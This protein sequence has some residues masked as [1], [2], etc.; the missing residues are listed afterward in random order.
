MQQIIKAGPHRNTL[1][2]IGIPLAVGVVA[3]FIP[4]VRNLHFESAMIASIAGCFIAAFVSARLPGKV[5]E[6]NHL[7]KIGGWIYLTA[8]V[9]LISALIRGCFSMDGLLFWIFNPSLS[10]LF[11]Y[12]VGRYFRIN[13]FRRSALWANLI[14]IFVAIG[15]LLFELYSLPQLYFFNHVWGYWPGPIYDEEVTFTTSVILFRFITLC[16]VGLFWLI[17]HFW[18]HRQ[19]QYLTLIIL[20]GLT[21]SY[22]RLSESGIVSPNEYI[23]QQLGSAEHTES[24]ELFF[25]EDHTPEP[26]LNRLR[27]LHEF[28]IGELADTLNVDSDAI[29]SYIYPHAWKKKK[30]TGAKFTSYV[31]VWHSRD[32]LHINRQ[33]VD[34]SLRH[35]LTHVI[36]KEFGNRLLN[37]SWSIGLLEGV[38]V[39]LAPAEQRRATADQMVVANEAWLEPEELNRLFSITG[40]Y[41]QAGPMSY[42]IAGSFVGYLLKNYPVEKFKTA[43]RRSSLDAGYETPLDSLQAGW[44]RHL[45]TVEVDEKAEMAGLQAFAIPSIFDQECPRLV[46]TFQDAIDRYRHHL[47]E[48]DTS[49]AL[50][51]LDDAI[52]AEPDNPDAVYQ[53]VRLLAFQQQWEEILNR[54]IPREKEW[55]RPLLI[56]SDAKKSTGKPEEANSLLDSLKVIDSENQKYRRALSLR[57]SYWDDFLDVNYRS[58]QLT[59]EHTAQLPEDLQ[60]IWLSQLLQKEKY[61][62]LIEAAPELK[63]NYTSGYHR[64]L[65]RISEYLGANGRSETAIEWLQSVPREDLR[66]V[67]RDQLEQAKRFV[68]FTSD[69]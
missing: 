25:S 35:E 56:T 7:L 47:A 68:E 29:S 40:F 6:A 21:L 44:K 60:W 58:A 69:F 46:T 37:A 34:G 48:Q 24:A 57:S 30:L 64:Q 45:K 59:A 36:S 27:A 22:L 15:L 28:H 10:I 50:N 4:L 54:E 13:G 33:A 11:G 63:P 49:G 41:R 62:Q 14:L 66:P 61:N 9:L 8:V 43:Y 39:A 42:T 55:I 2:Q 3:L 53:K 26:E 38:A 20:I 32:Q 12:A 23:E 31:P 18:D 19:A 16:W 52:R 65:I 67:M 51:A 17:P 5:N 1:I